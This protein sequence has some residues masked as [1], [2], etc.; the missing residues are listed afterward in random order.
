MKANADKK[1]DTLQ[2]VYGDIHARISQDGTG[3]NPKSKTNVRLI[4]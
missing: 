3:S 2:R 1:K 4:N